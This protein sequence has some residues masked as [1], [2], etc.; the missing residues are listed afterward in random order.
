M[1]RRWL[2]VGSLVLLVLQVIVQ[3]RLASLDSQ[4]T[5]E[6]VHLSAGYTYLARDDFRFNPEHPPL[7]K[8]LA[9]LPI[10][11]LKP[12]VTAEMEQNWT[13]SSDFFYDSWRENR[14]FGETMLYQSGN[15][16]D[17]LLFYG[18]LP[19]IGLTLLLGLTIFL[20]ALRHWGGGA[21]LTATALYVFNPTVN[22]HGHLITTDIAVSLGYLLS[23]YSFWR[24]VEKPTW[25]NAIWL[26]LALGLA[27]LSKHTAIIL[28]P[29]FV[30][31][32]L[33]YSA[34]K[35]DWSNWK[36]VGLKFIG[37]LVI[38]WVVIWAGFGFHDRSIPNV[39]SPSL[40]AKIS[41]HATAQ[42]SD[43]ATDRA[44][45][46]IRPVINIL[47][48]DYVKGMFLVLTHASGGH[49]S[50]LLGQT[51]KTGWWYYFPL[52]FLLKTPLAALLVLGGALAVLVRRQPRDSLVIA[53]V[54]AAAV[55]FGFAL[56]SKADLGIRHIL[57]I[58]PPLFIVAGW[59]ST[60]SQKLRLISA[61]LLVWLA[62]VSIIS[63]PTYLGYFN[64]LA[65]GSN[66]GYKI[67]TDSNL[68]WGQ[69]L[70]RISR[71][72]ESNNIKQPFIEYGW[73]GRSALDY[74]LGKD[75]YRL[76]GERPLGQIGVA[77]IG[78]SAYN[79]PQ[80]AYLTNCPN[81]QFIS[82]GTIVCHLASSP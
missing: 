13:K 39:E 38:S 14:A 7:V 80:F 57:P 71:Y 29:F 62:L 65:G 10:L 78:A 46:F 19:M 32:A 48:G 72:V 77:I 21:A 31:Y 58:F 59:A 52:L 26:G 17:L 51:S 36:S 55:F 47:P 73:D 81:R 15:N 42:L 54:V 76:L 25:K 50:F 43:P 79:Q 82:S 24:L 12:N 44:F 6:G 53:L 60:V 22:G 35:R 30:L 49:D 74:Y 16:P 8:I 4:T 66:N 18:R 27:L 9:A 3:I 64:E 40:L 68:D 75:N 69:D 45:K 20:I 2:I 34:L 33:G 5:D 63:F 11:A 56:T 70:K 28:L 41:N 23:G 1:T 37:A 61:F 67:A